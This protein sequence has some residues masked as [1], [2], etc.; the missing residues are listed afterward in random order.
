M[1]ELAEVE[2]NRR[3]WSDGHSSK[4]REVFLRGEKRVF[5][6]LD[7]RRVPIELTG[8]VLRASESHGK[9]MMF[10]FGGQVFLGVHL[11]MTGSLRTESP[12]YRPERHD[13][14]VL[15]QAKRALVFN[16][17]RLFGRI[18]FSV[19]E[20]PESWR[21]R[22]PAVL[23]AEF[24]TRYVGSHLKRR[25]RSPL[26]AVLLDQAIFPG[27]GNWMADEILWRAELH[28]SRPAGGLTPE[29]LRRIRKESRW[30]CREAIRRIADRGVD[31]PKSWL[32][33]HRWS[34]GGICPRTGAALVRE[35]IGGRT[36]CWSPGRQPIHF[37]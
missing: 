18:L 1:P 30:V 9:Q 3:V 12:D 15:F 2:R 37:T 10:C 21:D 24:T 32:F 17:P 26:K 27:V 33:P 7:A 8:R 11:G 25:A 29:E 19:G 35:P 4:V 20:A 36:T 23:S 16:D 31:P 28:P 14:I 5:R 34:D 6:G 22:A 13:H